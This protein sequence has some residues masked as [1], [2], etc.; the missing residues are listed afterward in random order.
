MT[1][2]KI[3]AAART[4]QPPESFPLKTR[5]ED[6]APKILSH[7]G[8]SISPD[9]DANLL[10]HMELKECMIYLANHLSADTPLFVQNTNS[11]SSL[12]C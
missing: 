6:G 8:D 4:D 3:V 2:G 5:E 7:A 11:D 9:F 12:D 10:D 1:L